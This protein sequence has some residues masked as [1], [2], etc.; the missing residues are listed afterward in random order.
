[1]ITD[2]QLIQVLRLTS[3]PNNS[4]DDPADDVEWWGH[5]TA[6]GTT[7]ELLSQMRDILGLRPVNVCTVTG[8]LDFRGL[9]CSRK[10][11][12]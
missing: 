9:E 10:T 5:D 12:P 8:A 1:M 11:R 7:A 4:R 6:V 3:E 2:K